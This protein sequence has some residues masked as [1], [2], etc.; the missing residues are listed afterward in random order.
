MVHSRFYRTVAG[1]FMDRGGDQG[2]MKLWFCRATSFRYPR[3]P[4]T[5]HPSAHT[6][7][8]TAA[9]LPHHHCARLWAARLGAYSSYG[10]P[11]V[12]NRLVPATFP[13]PSAYGARQRQAARR[14]IYPTPPPPP[15]PCR[16]QTRC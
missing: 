13:P 9:A 15:M 6:T 14:R 3:A 16:R 1:G 11:P 8:A 12:T 4:R 10:T 2:L 7:A 5:P